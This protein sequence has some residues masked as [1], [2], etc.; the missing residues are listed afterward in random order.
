MMKRIHP[1]KAL[2]LMFAFAAMLAFAACSSEED[3]PLRDGDWPPMKWKLTEGS[4]E[5]DGDFYVVPAAGATYKFECLNY[6]VI[7]EGVNVNGVPNYY[8]QYLESLDSI[9]TTN[10]YF[11]MPGDAFE[12]EAK[13]QELT[14]TIKPNPGN[15]ERTIWVH[16]WCMDV[17]GSRSFKQ[18][19]GNP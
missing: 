5:M 17:A 6:Y 11:Y 9:Q 7:L 4:S 10:K 18:K 19:P 3:E 2:R 12:V 15:A 1:M 16:V 14:V 13:E 8:G